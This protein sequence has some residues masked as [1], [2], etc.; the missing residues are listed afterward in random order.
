MIFFHSIRKKFETIFDTE[1][2]AFRKAQVLAPVFYY[3][4]VFFSFQ[5]LEG[6]KFQVA[7]PH[8]LTT[9][10]WPLFWAQHMDFAATVTVVLLFFVTSSLIGAFYS[11]HRLARIAAFLGMLFFHA[12]TNASGVNH[13][14][15][16]WLWVSFLLL[17]LPGGWGFYK[18]RSDNNSF[19]KKFL[20]V[21][22]SV[23]GYVLLTYTMSGIGKFIGSFEQLQRGGATLLSPDSASLTVASQLLQM[24]QDSVLGTFI[25]THP[26]LAWIG[27]LVIFYVQI[28]AF[29]VAFRPAL[30]RLWALF[31]ILFHLATYLA[32]NA[33]FVA[34]TLLLTVFFFDSPFADRE[35]SLKNQLK[36]F[37]LFGTLFV[38]VMWGRV[39]KHTNRP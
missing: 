8:T 15:D 32:M 17:F 22:W 21:F 4:L 9:L 36:A 2:N 23:Q 28:T 10:T 16:V 13:Q 35:I 30:H 33:I 34:P 39:T 19:R 24:Q 12:Y 37:P 26:I 5:Q 31:L 7:H 3:I 25:L 11:V 38:R 29:S 27:F 1:E 20:L 6:L 14:Y 18:Y